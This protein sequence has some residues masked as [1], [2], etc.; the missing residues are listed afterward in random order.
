MYAVIGIFEQ[1]LIDQ[2]HE[3]WEGLRAENLSHYADEVENRE[4]HVTLASFETEDINVWVEKLRLCL[5]SYSR[6]SLHFNQL[7]SFLGARIL[8]LNPIKTLELSQFHLAIHQVL[9]EAVS[10]ASLYHPDNWIPHLT[11]ANRVPEEKFV[12]AYAY[13]L[14]RLRPLSAQMIA[15]KVIKIKENK[16]VE[17]IF[18]YPL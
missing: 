2:V 13:C 17:T 4:P 5:S 15:V 8:T 1:E 9:A 6:L 18:D 3:I 14:E 12:R 10:S 7:S 16:Q 11:L